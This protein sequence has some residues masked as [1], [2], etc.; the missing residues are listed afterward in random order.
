MHFIARASMHVVRETL[1]R[2]QPCA[3]LERRN[4]LMSAVATAYALGGDGA[5]VDLII[6][7]ALDPPAPVTDG[8]YR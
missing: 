1:R 5:V 3:D 7:G 2:V 6:E 4:A 8:S